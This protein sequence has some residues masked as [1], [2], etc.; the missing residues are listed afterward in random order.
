MDNKDRII[1]VTARCI[2]TVAFEYDVDKRPCSYCGEMTW[3]SRSWREKRIDKIVCGM[4][5]T[6]EKYQ[7]K[8][9]SAN[10]TEETVNDT[11]KLVKE[12]YSPNMTEE[13]IMERMMKVVEKEI[14]RKINIVPNK[15]VK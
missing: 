12:R 1:I 7:E 10:V 3:V 9:F 4:C 8:D 15:E 14:G 6:K 2:D 11:I 5:F 13:E